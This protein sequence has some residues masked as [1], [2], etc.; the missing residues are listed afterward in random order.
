MDKIKFVVSFNNIINDIVIPDED[1]IEIIDILKTRGSINFNFV[2]DTNKSQQ[3][4]ILNAIYE[5]ILNFYRIYL[6]Q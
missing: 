1:F 3:Q 4:N 2:I 6:G 5:D